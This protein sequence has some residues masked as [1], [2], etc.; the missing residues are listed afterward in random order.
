MGTRKNHEL[1]T[2]ERVGSDTSLSVP[3]RKIRVTVTEGVDRGRTIEL[4]DRHLLVG[5]AE[6]CD[7][8]LT[9]PTVSAMHVELA[10]A[11]DGV[12]VRNLGSRNGVQVGVARVEEAVVEVPTAILLGRTVLGLRPMEDETHRPLAAV[13]R[14]GGL[15]GRSLKMK[16]AFGLIQQFA[17]SDATVLIEGATGTG[18][19][20]AARA[21]HDLSPRKAG[22][23]EIVDC[24]AIPAHLMEAELFGHAR[25][26]YTGADVARPGVFER[27]DGGTVVLDEIGE[28]PLELQPKLLGVLERGQVRRLGD[29]SPRK[30]SVRVIATTNR[31]L[32]REVQSTRFR[33]DLYFRLTVLRLALPPLRDRRE[34]V[35]LLAGDILGEKFPMPGAWLRVLERHEW[36]GNVRELRNVLERARA[37]AIERPG[38]VALDITLDGGGPINPLEEARR[39]FERDYLKHLLA[40]SGDNVRKAAKLAGLT[41]QGLYALLARHGLR[42]GN[43]GES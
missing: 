35:S 36:P 11:E 25:G 34:D 1:A 16:L 9:D 8:Q 5:R 3:L 2:T 26:A 20:L 28:L 41:R 33:Q 7:L 12:L 31:V 32:A 4:A 18:K 30:V 15:V 27:A 24:G 13:Q 29:Q 37:R 21:I 17:N 10:L 40:R 42:G 19:E 22:P 23:Y 43:E 39:S 14:L 6:A 38:D